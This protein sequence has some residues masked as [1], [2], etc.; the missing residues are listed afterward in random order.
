LGLVEIAYQIGA[1]EA[2]HLA[3]TRLF[4]GEQLPSDRA[5]AQWRFA[6]VADA[7]KALTA[8]GYLGRGKT[9]AF[10]GPLSRQC[11]GVF[12]L[13]PETTEDQQEPTLASPVASPPGAGDGTTG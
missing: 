7:A 5:F 10:P 4:L 12:G 13:V 2:Q 9:T 6:A 11:R 1:V 8:A 3:L